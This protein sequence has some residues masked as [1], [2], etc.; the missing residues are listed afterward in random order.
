MIMLN[1]CY[2]KFYKDFNKL[3]E[4]VKLRYGEYFKI[5]ILVV[6]VNV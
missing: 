4:V 1:Y 3:I 6:I 5:I 2:V